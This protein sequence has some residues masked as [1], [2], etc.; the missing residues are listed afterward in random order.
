LKHMPALRVPAAL[1]LAAALLA[2][3]CGDPPDREMQQA[4]GA[5]DAA[6]AAGA[7]LYATEEFKAAQEALERANDAV[8]IGDYRLALNHA[9]DSRERAQNAAK[10]SADGM[11]AAR[12]E[13]DH[14]L[15]NL[16]AALSAAEAAL[17]QAE[18]RR[19]P[20]RALTELRRAIDESRGALQEARAS[21][22]K[23]DY[24]AVSKSARAAGD[25]LDAAVKEVEPASAPTTRR[26]R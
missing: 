2:S 12:V 1:V 8:E 5:I 19:A 18:A 13:A 21:L 20:A 7:E 3:A 23:G 11:A 10:M 17:K 26:A 22:E 24:G 6:R 14:A 16:D 9:L 25:A 15:T 4:Q